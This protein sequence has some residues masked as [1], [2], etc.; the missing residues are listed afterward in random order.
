[1]KHHNQG[2]QNQVYEIK[3]YH[4]IAAGMTN[5]ASANRYNKEIANNWET[6]AKARVENTYSRTEVWVEFLAAAV[7]IAAVTMVFI[8]EVV[9]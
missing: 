3:D 8:L 9:K 6:I 5:S 2:W 1:M 7:M 4:R